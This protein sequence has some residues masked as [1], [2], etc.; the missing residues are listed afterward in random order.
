MFIFH[1]KRL[2][3]KHQL[4][5]TYE[6]VNRAVYEAK[7]ILGNYIPTEINEVNSNLPK[8]AHI[9]VSAEIIL[10]ATRLLAHWFHLTPE[11]V[12]YGLPKID[13]FQTAIRDICPSLLKPLKCEPSE[14]RTLS[15]MC[16]NL[17]YQSWGSSRSAYI[18]FLPPAYADGI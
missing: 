4:C 6:D 1:F 8:E 2:N 12:I 11:A 10:E 9:A 14:Y 18:R 13:T 17:E 5:I 7:S 3:Y 16:N 15:G